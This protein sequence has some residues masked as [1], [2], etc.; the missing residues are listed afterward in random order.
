MGS[1]VA[2]VQGA[3]TPGSRGP[4][5]TGSHLV[6]TKSKGGEM[7]GG[8]T[9]EGFISVRPTPVRQWTS[10]SNTVFKMPSGLYKKNVGQRAV[11]SVQVSREGQI[12]HCLGVCY[13]G[14]CCLRAALRA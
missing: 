5:Q 3:R 7:S 2:E 13:A 10:V 1:T 9:R 12:D 11:G 14:S 8:E 6:L 4:L